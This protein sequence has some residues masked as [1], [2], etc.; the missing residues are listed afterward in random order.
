MEQLCSEP[1]IN[2]PN[3]FKYLLQNVMRLFF[4]GSF[5]SYGLAKES[6]IDGLWGRLEC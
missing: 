4:W 1:Q 6:P 5:S 3:F 2:I